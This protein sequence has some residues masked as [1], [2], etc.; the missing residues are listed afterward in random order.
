MFEL[1]EPKDDGLLMR[2]VGE[3]SRDKHYFLRRYIDAF[4]TAMKDKNWEGLHYID[5]FAGAG[6]EKIRGTDELTW[7]SPLIAAQ[8]PNPFTR[9]HLCEKG[10]KYY[11]ALVK[12][13]S[14]I[15]P[16][17]QILNGDANKKIYEIINAIPDGSLSLA[18]LD[19]YGLHLDYET[20]KVLSGKRSDL[21]ILLADHMDALRN[22]F[23]YYLDNPKSNLD[24]FLGPGVNWREKL[25]ECP[26]DRRVEE[27][28]KMYEQQIHKLGY[29][30]FIPE[31]I[32]RKKAPL[33][34]LIFCS[35]ADNAAKLWRDIAEKKPDGQRTFNFDD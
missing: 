9:L 27:L 17:S 4:T 26:K 11:R 3:W 2:E 18:F 1:P 6:I 24:R 8:A 19:P 20:L 15:A 23:A 28:R 35:R 16:K 5:L 32:S 25:M 14:A 33:Y 30:Y 31:R 34:S 7:G 21:I 22:W 12:R 10:K 29:D 13:V